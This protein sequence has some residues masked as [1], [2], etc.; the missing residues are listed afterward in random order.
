M[1]CSVFGIRTAEELDY[2][3]LSST[4]DVELRQY[5]P[6]IA[7]QATLKG[8]YGDVQGNLF[9]ILAG[10]IF[11]GNASQEDIAMTAPVVM[12]EPEHGAAG[13]SGEAESERIAMTAPVTMAVSAGG[14]WTMSFSMPAKYSITS[15]PKP[16]NEKVSLV[17]MPDRTV[18]VVRFS[19]FFDDTAKRVEGERILMQWL[20]SRPDYRRAGELFYAGYDPPFTLPFLRRNEVLI[21]VERL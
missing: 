2:V 13:G 11:G 10:Y 19:G 1:G 15:L 17:E 4:S 18:A 5:A 7:A 16:L 14:L 8:S 9:R 21:V 12:A 6:H 3:V 20:E